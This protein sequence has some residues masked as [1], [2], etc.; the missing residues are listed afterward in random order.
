MEIRDAARKICAALGETEIGATRQVEHIIRRQGVAWAHALQA[1]VATLEAQGGMLRPDGQ[2]RTPGGEFLYLAYQRIRSRRSAER[3]TPSKPGPAQPL[4]WTDRL[5]AVDEAVQTKG[6]LMG[7][8]IELT[9]RPGSVSRRNETVVL[10]LE[11]SH[12]GPLPKTVPLPPAVPTRYIVYV[13]AKQWP[14]IEAALKNPEDILIVNGYCTYDEAGKGIAVLATH[15]TTKL[16]KTAGRRIP[17]K[18]L[19]RPDIPPRPVVQAAP[20]LRPEPGIPPTPTPPARYPKGQKVRHAQFG[21]GEVVDCRVTD[22][23]EEVYVD[24]EGV[25]F[26]RLSGD[27]AGLEIVKLPK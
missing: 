20:A 5:E 25:G 18:P 9:G 22:R 23:G 19:R 8:K 3:P 15:V 16:T 4:V 7:A 12:F 24:F 11:D 26:R 1:E 17:G 10:V 6:Q 13:A 21:M 27:A 2:R 14:P